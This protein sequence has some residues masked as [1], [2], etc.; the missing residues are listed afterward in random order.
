MRVNSIINAL[1]FVRTIQYSNVL[2]ETYKMTRCR[3]CHSNRTLCW[4]WASHSDL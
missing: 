2:N 3:S 4:P 1:I